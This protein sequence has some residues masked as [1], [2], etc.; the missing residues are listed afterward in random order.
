MTN[1]FIAALRKGLAPVHQE[2]LDEIASSPVVREVLERADSAT[3][4][5]RAKLTKRLEELPRAYAKQR[6]ALGAECN[7]AY[8]AESRAEE[9]LAA[10]RKARVDACGR[11]GGIETR[12]RIEEAEIR[13]ELLRTAP[14]IVI[15]ASRAVNAFSLE[16]FQPPIPVVVRPFDWNE[17]PHV[18]AENALAEARGH[19][20]VAEII[21]NIHA[22]IDGLAKARKALD[23]LK[24][25]PLPAADATERCAAVLAELNALLVSMRDAP[26]LVIDENLD[27]SLKY[28]QDQTAF[29]IK[30]SLV[31]EAK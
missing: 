28:G 21:A 12:M 19:A 17:A 20:V 24:F 31:S 23:E 18:Q 2:T 16:R 26:Q 13:S 10:A 5:T 4:K 15:A 30:T 1:P 8:A 6:E 3:V 11:A 9:S 22:A 29:T 25:E 7:A 14:A 27:V